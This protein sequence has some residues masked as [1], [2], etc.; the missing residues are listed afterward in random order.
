LK[1][2]T[3][4]IDEN[5][6]E[7]DIDTF[8]YKGEPFTGV[9]MLYYDNGKP[10]YKTM[11]KNG[12]VHGSM[13]CYFESGEIKYI[14]ESRKGLRHGETKRWLPNGQLQ[15]FELYDRGFLLSRNLWSVDGKLIE[16]EAI[17][18][19]SSDYDLLQFF[20]KNDPESSEE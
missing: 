17:S 8:L 4:I 9:G 20:R 18:E 14:I 13:T 5:E 12:F 19:D 11:Y 6:L 15:L 1:E 16:T 10:E 2:E 7:Q 3:L